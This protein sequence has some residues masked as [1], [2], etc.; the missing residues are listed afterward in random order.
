MLMDQ[1]YLNRFIYIYIIEILNQVTIH[2]NQA[3]IFDYMNT[4]REN[5]KW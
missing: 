5:H 1:I 2:A 4:W 3:G